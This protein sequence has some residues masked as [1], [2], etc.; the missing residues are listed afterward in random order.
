MTTDEAQAALR[1]DL[2]LVDEE[3]AD[4]RR[5]VR[6]LR[7]QIR[8]TGPSDPED[9]TAAITAADEQE[10]LVSALETRR[11]RLRRQLGLD[12]D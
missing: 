10:A 3:L 6:E 11:D 12:R 8:D 7:N 4:L 5:T 1:E 9:R 2:R